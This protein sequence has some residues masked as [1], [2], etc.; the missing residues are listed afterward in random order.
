MTEALEEVNFKRIITWFCNLSNEVRCHYL[1]TKSWR[2]DY[3]SSP[4]LLVLEIEL[5][6]I[7]AFLN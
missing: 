1:V 5:D 4:D 6:L 2:L 3:M 7:I